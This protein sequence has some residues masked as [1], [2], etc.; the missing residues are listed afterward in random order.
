MSLFHILPRT[1]IEGIIVCSASSAWCEQDGSEWMSHNSDNGNSTHKALGVQ[2]DRYIY[3][4]LLHPPSA[5]VDSINNHTVDDRLIAQEMITAALL[6]MKDWQKGERVLRTYYGTYGLGLG[7][8]SPLLSSRAHDALT[9][10]ASSRLMV[11]LSEY[12]EKM[13]KELFCILLRLDVTSDPFIAAHPPEHRIA[14]DWSMV[15]DNNDHGMQEGK[16]LFVLGQRPSQTGF[17]TLPFSGAGKVKWIV[18][19]GSEARTGSRDWDRSSATVI[20]H[21]VRDQATDTTT[22][23]QGMVTAAVGLEYW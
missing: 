13:P 23:A 17:K 10:W 1:R 4:G 21:A 3:L 22:S 6:G 16:M 20:Q 9:W 15:D 19:F 14:T 12:S 11:I 2:I 7:W 8:M 18:R 5:V